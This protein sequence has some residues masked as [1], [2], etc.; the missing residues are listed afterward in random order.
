M[1]LLMEGI[2]S[3]IEQLS[4]TYLS[5]LFYY[6]SS[7]FPTEGLTSNILIIEKNNGDKEAAKHV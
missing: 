4:S 2:N 7:T 6:I 3:I 1:K 5:H